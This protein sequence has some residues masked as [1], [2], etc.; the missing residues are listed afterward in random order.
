VGADHILE[1]DIRRATRFVQVSWKAL[2]CLTSHA[3]HP[4]ACAGPSSPLC[5]PQPLS[6]AIS[7]DA[8]RT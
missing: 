6:H 7:L 8:S 3:V 5:A 1:S 4:G 2:I